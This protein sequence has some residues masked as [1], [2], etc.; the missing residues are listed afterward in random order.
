MTQW[1]WV[2]TPRATFAVEVQAEQVIQGAPYA[3]AILRK[4][5]TRDVRVLLRELGRKSSVRTVYLP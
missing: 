1:L 5:K 4:L 2:S 3:M